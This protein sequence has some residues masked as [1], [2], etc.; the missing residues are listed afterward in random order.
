M[1]L[2]GCVKAINQ[3]NTEKNNVSLTSGIRLGA[4][5]QIKYKVESFTKNN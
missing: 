4:L 1:M 3:W 2:V 5:A